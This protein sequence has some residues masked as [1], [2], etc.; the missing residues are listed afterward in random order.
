MSVFVL[1]SDKRPLMP[2]SEKRARLLLT[3]K[4]AA[5]FRRYPF[6]IILNDRTQDD[7][8]LQSVEIK[9]DPGSK[10]TG[11]AVVRS[12]AGNKP[13]IVLFLA[14]IEHRGTAIR[15]KLAA[16]TAFRRRRRGA[17]LR[18]RAARFDNRTKPTGWLAPSLR[19]R[20]ETTGSWVSR[21]RRLCPVVGI[22]MEL[23]RFDTHALVNPEVS[24]VE[25]Q[26]G[27]LA[28]TE[29]R[30]YLLAKWSRACCYCG[31][32]DV[33]LNIDHIAPRARGGSDRIA[34]LT[35][36]CIPCNQAKGSQPVEAFVIDPKRLA[37]IKAQAKTP[38]RD[39]A[40][41]NSVRWALFEALK[42]TGLPMRCGSGGRTKWNRSRLGIPKTHALDAACVA[43]V[44]ALSGW[45]VPTLAIKCT[46]RGQY[47]RTKLD[48]F[49]FPRLK[50]MR[51][52][53]VRGFATGDMVR[54]VVP[55]GTKAGTY[56][57][58]IAVRASG[59]FNIQTKE[60]VIQGINHK[61]CAVVARGDGYSF[62][63]SRRPE[64]ALAAQ[65]A[66]HPRPEGRGISRRF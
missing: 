33:P 10:T 43:E 8:E 65:N 47:Q 3:R 17:N 6:T 27:T 23:V 61:Y 46:G 2:C 4:R 31:V 20:V 56:V 29:V 19:H 21:L 64:P 40:V 24:G 48:R 54:A 37:R 51:Q 14:E 49:G 50:L 30:E 36:A 5:V 34:N 55:T 63:Q 60:A 22:A 58:R 42:A 15:K 35:L 18:Y 26:H 52:K 28:G 12:G 32:T 66:I 39:A 13:D 44:E 62:A 38:L 25:Y 45:Q 7:C 59:S 9:I 1:G 11:L 53:S 41:V 16:R 57:G